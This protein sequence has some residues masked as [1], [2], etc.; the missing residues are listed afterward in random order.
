ML[1][2]LLSDPAIYFLVGF[3]IIASLVVYR[4]RNWFKKEL[5]RWRLSE[6]NA[7]PA[8]FSRQEDVNDRKIGI[9]IGDGAELI[10]TTLEDVVGGDRVESNTKTSDFNRTSGIKIGKKVKLKKT[11]MKKITGGSE[12]KR[13]QS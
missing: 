6:V 1:S 5:V 11:K 8:K 3:I 2:Y 10:D 7:G 4:K 13:D 12:I 9:E